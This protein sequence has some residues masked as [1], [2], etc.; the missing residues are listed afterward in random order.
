MLR[1]QTKRRE[2]GDDHRA[3]VAKIDVPNAS[4]A[5]AKPHRVFLAAVP[6]VF[7][8]LP[9]PMTSSVFL[10]APELLPNVIEGLETASIVVF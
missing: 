8:L 6:L 1:D 2:V 4:V 10:S 9:D 3:V 5:R 7:N